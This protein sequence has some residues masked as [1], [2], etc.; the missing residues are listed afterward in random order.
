MLHAVVAAARHGQSRRRRRAGDPKL[1]HHRAPLGALDLRACVR[2]LQAVAPVPLRAAAVPPWVLHAASNRPGGLSNRLEA[3]RGQSR[4]ERGGGGV[5]RWK[6]KQRP[7]RLTVVGCPAESLRCATASKRAVHRGLYS[8]S[9]SA[10]C[11]RRCW[12]TR[13][14]TTQHTHQV[15]PGHTRSHC[16]RWRVPSCLI[17]PRYPLQCFIPPYWSL[18]LPEALR[19]AAPASSPS[20]LPFESPS[21]RQRLALRLPALSLR[22]APPS[23][24][25]AWLRRTW[26]ACAALHPPH[27]TRPPEP[28]LPAHPGYPAARAQVQPSGGKRLD[29]QSGP[30]KCCA[31][32]A[33]TQ[34]PPACCKR[35]RPC[36]V[37]QGAVAVRDS[38][39]RLRP[40]SVAPQQARTILPSRVSCLA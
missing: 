36:N 40:N 37:P 17:R 27:P 39:P 12:A 16:V 32:H 2:V 21:S 3:A 23:R 31:R 18:P 1:R 25:P 34:A 22:T 10:A 28:R 7:E 26:S 38:R 14:A 33:H 4:G 11:L 13:P 15:T 30:H 24:T 8:A 6:S 35:P 19:P 9:D 5:D 20:P 29:A